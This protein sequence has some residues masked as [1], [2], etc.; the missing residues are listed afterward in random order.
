MMSAGS[1]VLVRFS[2][3]K[4]LFPAI[5]TIEQCHAVTRWDAVEGHVHL[6]MKLNFPT[7]ALPSEIMKLDGVGQFLAYDVLLDEKECKTITPDR[8]HAYVF[9]EI[10]PAKI[11]NVKN[12][13][14]KIESVLFCHRING[15]CDLVA[16]ISGD[17]FEVID[18]IIRENLLRLD[19]ILRLKVDRIIDLQQL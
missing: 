9:I 5:K 14:E 3:P 15:G 4:K 19:G 18:R 16:V 13:L 1:Y 2:D 7:S 12:T 8:C 17:N 6:V 10:E 11:N